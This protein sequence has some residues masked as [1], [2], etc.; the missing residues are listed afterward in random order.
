MG[1]YILHFLLLY[2]LSVMSQE[3]RLPEKRIVLLLLCLSASEL[4]Q[5]LLFYNCSVVSDKKNLFLLLEVFVKCLRKPSKADDET[6][7]QDILRH[8]PNRRTLYIRLFGTTDFDKKEDQLLAAFRELHHFIRQFIAWQALQKDA[9]KIQE[10]VLQRLA[11]HGSEELF[12]H[13]WKEWEA[14]IGDV[15]EGHHFYYQHLLLHL[16]RESHWTFD[17]QEQLS[18]GYTQS[19]RACL[20]FLQQGATSAESSNSGFHPAAAHPETP[21]TSLSHPPML[22]RLYALLTQWKQQPHITPEDW[23]AFWNRYDSCF[24]AARFDQQQCET[25]FQTLINIHIGHIIKGEAEALLRFR[26]TWQ[27]AKGYPFYKTWTLSP[28]TYFNF[29]AACVRLRAPDDLRNFLDTYSQ[30]LPAG[31]RQEAATLGAAYLA[32][33]SGNLYAARQHLDEMKK[34][35]LVFGTRLH[36]LRLRIACELSATEYIDIETELDAY[37]NYFDHK[38]QRIRPDRLEAYKRLGLFVRKIVRLQRRKM[39]REDI[40]TQ[41]INLLSELER[42]ATPKP[43]LYEWIRERVVSL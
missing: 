42:A 18:T 6:A 36:T 41:K 22:P 37:R 26:E 30:R 31:L 16:T 19:M 1:R 13:E 8:L 14:H 27:R 34:R 40:E 20:D 21:Q 28:A 11:A 43:I 7:L 25:I 3:T 12:K 24:S 5:I 23:Q 38:E 35:K 33:C 10:Y 4:K 15:P 17:R 2:F 29:V 39:L 9:P 32:Y